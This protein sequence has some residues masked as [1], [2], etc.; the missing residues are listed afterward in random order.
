MGSGKPMRVL[1]SIFSVNE[2]ILHIRKILEVLGCEVEV[3]Y[4]DAYR[5]V[6]PYYRKKIDELGF[7]SAKR[8]YLKSVHEKSESV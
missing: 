3:I 6:C 8:D 7:H 1:L 4:S 2:Q 5:Q